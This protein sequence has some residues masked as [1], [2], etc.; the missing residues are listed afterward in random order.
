MKAFSSMESSSVEFE[1]MV[2]SQL[3]EVMPYFD[4]GTNTG[5]SRHEK[6]I[7]LV[8][9]LI[10]SAMVEEIFFVGQKHICHPI[11]RPVV[12]QILPSELI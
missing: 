10:D 9:P 12:S 8:Y 2:D 5:A 7:I 11:V 4:Y 6:S 3:K 1:R